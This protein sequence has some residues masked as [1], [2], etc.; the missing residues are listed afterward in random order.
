MN[1]YNKEEVINIGTG[2]DL[3]IKELANLIRN[4]SGFEGKI[5]WNKSKPDGT[6]RKLMDVN[7]IN[8]LGWKYKISL[9]QGIK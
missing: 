4:I 5:I 3:S 8:S 6:P 7:K 9:E 2:S 1:N